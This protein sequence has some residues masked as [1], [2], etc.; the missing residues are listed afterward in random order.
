MISKDKFAVNNEYRP[1][2][3]EICHHSDFY[4]PETNTCLRCINIDKQLLQDKTVF[5]ARRASIPANI[6][7]KK[8][9]LFGT[10]N[11]TLI[12]LILFLCWNLI[13]MH[14]MVIFQLIYAGAGVSVAIGGMLADITEQVKF[15]EGLK[16]R[17]VDTA[18]VSKPFLLIHKFYSAIKSIGHSNADS[19]NK[20]LMR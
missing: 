3:C 15:I 7:F 20:K 17:N 1:T 16:K 13:P 2:R 8:M 19:D 10:L 5:V 12:C 14:F 11:F 4:N 6:F 18:N 9:L